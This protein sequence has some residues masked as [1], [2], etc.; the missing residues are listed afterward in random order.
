ME[1]LILSPSPTS[2][3]PSFENYCKNLSM[4][5]LRKLK[6]YQ[7]HKYNICM[8]IFENRYRE[9]AE[10]GFPL[11]GELPKEMKREILQYND[12]PT[13]S[14]RISK[15]IGTLTKDMYMKKCFQ[16]ITAEEIMKSGITHYTSP[17]LVKFELNKTH[18]LH[19]DSIGLR[20]YNFVDNR[21]IQS[22]LGSDFSGFTV[23]EHHI[24]YRDAETVL[25]NRQG[26]MSIYKK[27]VIEYILKKLDRLYNLK[28]KT[29]V[30]VKLI[31]NLVSMRVIPEDDINKYKQEDIPE[32]YE[33]LKQRI[34]KGQ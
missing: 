27:Y 30:F 32:L 20:N 8:K 29:Y 24:N 31:F 28:D 26:C 21:F 3:D 19:L 34:I 12:L 11:F 14:R 23:R 10:E 25:S 1:A 2:D 6:Q 18:H 9:I 33:M 17:L 5:D 16:P 7:E 22:P 13:R 4:D 15:S